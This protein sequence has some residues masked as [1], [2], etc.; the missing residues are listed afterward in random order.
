MTDEQYSFIN[1]IVRTRIG[2]TKNILNL[3]KYKMDIVKNL[4]NYESLDVTHNNP[5]K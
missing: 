4:N 5:V 1:E 2:R 3:V